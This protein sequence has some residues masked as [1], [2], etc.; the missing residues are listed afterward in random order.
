ML[1]EPLVLC[2]GRASPKPAGFSKG[3][4][5]TLALACAPQNCRETQIHPQSEH[6][7]LHRQPRSEV[8]FLTTERRG[9]GG[10]VRESLLEAGRAGGREG[11]V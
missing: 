1:V 9:K 6:P 11:E 3:T 7:H 5:E 2:S 4:Q 8:A 10:E